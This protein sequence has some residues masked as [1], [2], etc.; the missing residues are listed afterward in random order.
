[1]NSSANAELISMKTFSDGGLVASVEKDDDTQP[2]SSRGENWAEALAALQNPAVADAIK[3]LAALQQPGVAAALGALQRYIHKEQLSDS[4][5][6][7]RR[8]TLNTST[9]AAVKQTLKPI[10][11]NNL[12]IMAFTWTFLGLF[13]LYAADREITKADASLAIFSIY[14]VVQIILVLLILYVTQRQVKK[15]TKTHGITLG[16]LIQGWLALVYSFAGIY[17]FLQHAYQIGLVRPNSNVRVAACSSHLP[18]LSCRAL[19]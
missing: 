2:H 5:S 16:F 6:R 8:I 15:V 7:E 1:M 4:R 19:L 10:F 18:S 17:M 12:F 11:V 9:F 3:A 14:T 13:L